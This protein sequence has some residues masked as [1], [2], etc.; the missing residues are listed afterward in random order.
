MLI[1]Y[2]EAH[3]LDGWCIAMDSMQGPESLHE[4]GSHER[5]DFSGVRHIKR[6]IHDN[7]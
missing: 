3:R 6:D 4:I 2:V 1:R 7:A 5:C